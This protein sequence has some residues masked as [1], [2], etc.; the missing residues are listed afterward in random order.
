M[1]PVLEDDA[2]LFSLDDVLDSED[3]AGQDLPIGTSA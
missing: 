2:L 1:Q 3:A